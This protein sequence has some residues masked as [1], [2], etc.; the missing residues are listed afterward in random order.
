MAVTRGRAHKS[1]SDCYYFFTVVFHFA[2]FF[3]LR[4]NANACLINIMMSLQRF[5]TAQ[6]LIMATRVFA[7]LYFAFLMYQTPHTASKL[8]VTWVSVL[9]LTGFSL[10][11]GRYYVGII[12]T[13]LG[14]M[15]LRGVLWP[16]YFRSGGYISVVTLLVCVLMDSVGRWTPDF[17]W[18]A[19]EQPGTAT[20]NMAMPLTYASTG[21][22]W[23]ALHA[24]RIPYD[25]FVSFT[26]IIIY[27]GWKDMYL[28]YKM[29]R[30]AV[31]K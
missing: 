27:A 29:H 8:V 16:G 25:L 24:G 5:V 26:W 12:T 17:I 3:L 30:A 13:T 20:V 28:D 18:T 10:N 4:I 14:I 19:H 11:D 23:W 7:A 22:L 31:G 15:S 21:V 9:I 1:T 2:N 6:R